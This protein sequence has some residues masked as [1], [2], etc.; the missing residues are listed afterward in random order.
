MTQTALA[1]EFPWLHQDPAEILGDSR[2]HSIKELRGKSRL[3]QQMYR[4]W[5]ESYNSSYVQGWTYLTGSQAQS[6]EAKARLRRSYPTF[7]KAAGDLKDAVRKR[8]ANVAAQFPWAPSDPQSLLG[9]ARPKDIDELLE[10]GTSAK[11][12]DAFRSWLGTTT[13]ADQAWF[14]WVRSEGAT[15]QQWEQALDPTV[16]AFASDIGRLKDRLRETHGNKAERILRQV[17]EVADDVAQAVGLSGPQSSGAGGGG[18]AGAGGWQQAAPQGMQGTRAARAQQRAAQQGQ[19]GGGSAGRP[20]QPGG[21]QGGQQGGQPGGGRPGPGQQ[22]PPQ[23][24]Q[25][26]PLEGALRGQMD[27][28]HN[29]WPE[30]PNYATKVRWLGG[31]LQQWGGHFAETGGLVSAYAEAVEQYCQAYRGVGDYCRE[32]RQTPGADYAAG[33]VEYRNAVYG[34]AWTIDL[35]FQASYGDWPHRRLG[36]MITQVEESGNERVQGAARGPLRTALYYICEMYAVGAQA[37]NTAQMV[38]NQVPPGY[39]GGDSAEPWG[40]HEIVGA[41]AEAADTMERA[42]WPAGDERGEPDAT[43][44]EIAESIFGMDISMLYRLAGVRD[45]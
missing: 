36:Y 18:G 16:E 19:G 45:Y 17:G 25:R 34:V 23:R 30:A 43:A 28:G 10:P 15:T 21:Q 35:A 8:P 13:P 20:G 32:L 5:L 6:A 9:D 33:I 7:Y 31:L 41:H 29:L 4:D 12:A 27:L 2:P 11:W 38:V 14:D 26:N 37:L 44:D 40:T 3:W 1:T 22:P 42:H 24:P 39:Q